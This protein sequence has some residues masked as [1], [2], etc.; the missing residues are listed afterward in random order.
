MVVSEGNQDANTT[1]IAAALDDTVLM[2]GKSNLSI[3]AASKLDSAYPFA[4]DIA[5]PPQSSV[6][7]C[8]VDEG[9]S[10]E[11]ASNLES[12]QCMVKM[13]GMNYGDAPVRSHP[14]HV[15]LLLKGLGLVLRHSIVNCLLTWAL[16]I[17]I[18]Y[19]ISSEKFESEERL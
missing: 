18:P 2:R 12:L 15:S 9:Q 3:N 4:S 8:S 6:Y 7:G 5:R 16:K 17:L 10:S 13:A 14:E 11:T 1:P 19:P